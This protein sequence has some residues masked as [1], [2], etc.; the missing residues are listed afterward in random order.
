MSSPEPL[1]ADTYYHIFNRGNDGENLFREP[2]NYRYFLKLYL[3]HIE[4]IA[5]TFAYCLLPNHFHLLIH[6]RK[7]EEI[8]RAQQLKVIKNS[9]LLTP[10]QSFANLFSACSMAINKRYAR[11]GSLFEH[12][13]HRIRINNEQYLTR[14]VVYI[15]R[16][17]TKHRFTPDFRNWTYSSY[18]AILSDKPT[19][20]KR[21]HVTAWFG[22]QPNFKRLHEQFV[23]DNVVKHIILEDFD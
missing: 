8:E 20:I 14:L 22:D 21:D 1:Q 2:E 13:F 4:P 6:T 9:K 19:H 16:N 10:S 7:E 3:N 5:A 12:P 15:H 23:E 11:T 18:Q 17:P